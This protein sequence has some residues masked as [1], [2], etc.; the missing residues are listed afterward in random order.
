MPAIRG[1]ILTMK[2]RTALFVYPIHAEVSRSVDFDV[3]KLSRKTKGKGKA[4]TA[5][6]NKP[7]QQARIMQGADSDDAA[8]ADCSLLFQLRLICADLIWN[9][10]S[11][12]CGQIGQ[13]G[14]DPRS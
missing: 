10:V 3:R 6:K 5:S 2:A 1:M 13:T 12:R 8:P 7:K 14:Q 11:R 4:S 9:S